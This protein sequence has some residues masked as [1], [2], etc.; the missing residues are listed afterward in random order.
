MAVIVE[1]HRLD[2]HLGWVNHNHA[3]VCVRVNCQDFPLICC[4]VYGFYC[5][6]IPPPALRHVKDVT[7]LIESY[8]VGS[9]AVFVIDLHER[10]P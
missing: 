8:G 3:G 2:G 4:Q 5:C 9:D 7:G 6:R 10:F 1:I